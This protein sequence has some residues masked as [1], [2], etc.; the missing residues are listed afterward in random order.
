MVGVSGFA[1]SECLHQFPQRFVCYST[2]AHAGK[3]LP[4][5]QAEEVTSR[6]TGANNQWPPA[7]AKTPGREGSV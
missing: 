6:W 2:Q 3:H 7:V 5:A 1:L 4:G